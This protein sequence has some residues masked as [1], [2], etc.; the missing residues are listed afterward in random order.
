MWTLINHFL[1]LS[2][3]YSHCFRSRVLKR[4]SDS[5]AVS[6]FMLFESKLC[7]SSWF[8]WIEECSSCKFYCSYDSIFEIIFW[9]ES[10]ICW[11]SSAF[12]FLIS[13]T[14]YLLSDGFS[15]LLKVLLFA[16]CTFWIAC[17]WSS[18]RSY[19]NFY[20]SYLA[21]SERIWASLSM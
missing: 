20:F 10:I 12:C 17:Y 9:L 18:S 11:S 4:F 21:V 6:E 8:S 5:P 13:S 14:C 7:L 19:A 15:S 2:F 3:Q 16:S 1:C